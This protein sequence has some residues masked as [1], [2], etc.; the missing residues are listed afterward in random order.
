MN[1]AVEFT[2][3]R[4]PCR[5][6]VSAARS[7]MAGRYRDLARTYRAEGEMAICASLRE[8][9]FELARYYETIAH[10]VQP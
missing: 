10:Q 8:R 5:R 6:D 2:A 7:R 9:H 3:D 4:L 1:A